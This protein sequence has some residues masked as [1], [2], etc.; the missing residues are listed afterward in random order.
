MLFFAQRLVLFPSLRRLM[1]SLLART[2]PRRASPSRPGSE[3]IRLKEDG[4]AELQG[5]LSPERIRAIRDFL[6][7]LPLYDRFSEGRGLFRLEDAPAGCHVAVY[8][9]R[10][11]V[12][13]PEVAEVANDPRVLSIAAEVLGARPTISGVSA[14]WS[15]PAAEPPKDAE[16]FHRDVDDWAFVKLFVYLTDVSD[17]SGPHVFVR[18]SHLDNLLLRIRRYQD[19]EVEAVLDRRRIR[20]LC[21]KAGTAF[22]ENTFGLHKGRHPT[23]RRR[24][25]LQVQYSLFPIFA[26]DYEADRPLLIAEGRSRWTN[27]LY[28]RLTPS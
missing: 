6:A 22:L 11:L 17:D 27:R 19:A 25:L 20:V 14:W 1:A 23:T 2:L 12:R 8:R 13:C 18:G 9:E 26:E 24:L 7:E 10:D 15:L 16:L 28:W 5:L 3:A 21:G 4:F